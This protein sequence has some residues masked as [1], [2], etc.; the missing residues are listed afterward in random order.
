MSW[1]QKSSIWEDICLLKGTDVIDPDV[2]IDHVSKLKTI[3][4]IL[5][6]APS[7]SHSNYTP[8]IIT[9]ASVDMEILDN[10][11]SSRCKCI[12]MRSLPECQSLGT[13]TEPAGPSR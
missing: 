8:S 6:V 13:P 3:T 4:S 10:P 11:E 5:V 2:G 7:R 9:L 1:F 12:Y